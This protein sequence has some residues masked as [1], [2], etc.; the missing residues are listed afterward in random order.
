M[1]PSGCGV[2]LREGLKRTSMAYQNARAWLI[3]AMESASALV[4]SVD[5]YVTGPSAQEIV[6]IER[7]EASATR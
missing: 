3:A 6:A 4:V 1:R 7:A 5:H 2:A